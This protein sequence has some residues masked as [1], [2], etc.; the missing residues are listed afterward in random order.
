MSSVESVERWLTCQDWADCD[1]RMQPS[2]NTSE[3][4]INVSSHKHSFL[5][6]LKLWG[7]ACKH[8]HHDPQHQWMKHS[9]HT[10]SI[11]IM[12]KLDQCF[13]LLLFDESVVLCCRMYAFHCTN[14]DQ[15][16]PPAQSSTVHST[17][18]QFVNI[19]LVSLT[20]TQL[21]THLHK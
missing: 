2:R 9:S 5:V 13:L 20:L 8:W 18:Y 17:N 19:E 6:A 14:T 10:D 1:W 4:D 15:Y 3:W 16:W 11:L 12:L 21:E 7:S